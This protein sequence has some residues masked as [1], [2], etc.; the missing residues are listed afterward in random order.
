MI[1]QFFRKRVGEVENFLL[2]M[3]RGA[4]AQKKEKEKK[5]NAKSKR[6]LYRSQGAYSDVGSKHI[7]L[8]YRS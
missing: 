8:R 4:V 3:V 1:A 7:I 6:L 5:N 2:V